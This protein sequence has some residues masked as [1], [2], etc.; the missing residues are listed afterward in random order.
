[1]APPPARCG[2][3]GR[4]AR[5]AARCDEVGWP[6]LQGAAIAVEATSAEG[7]PAAVQAGVDEVRHRSGRAIAWLRAVLVVLALAAA[8]LQGSWVVRAG[9]EGAL[10]LATAITLGAVGVAVAWAGTRLVERAANRALDDCTGRL[11]RAHG[12]ALALARQEVSAQR[13]LVLAAQA[14][15]ETLARLIAHDLK[16]PL[17]AVLQLVSLAESRVATVP[18]LEAAREDLRLA[19]EEAQRLAGMVGDLLLVSRLEHGTLQPRRQAT[20]VAA[21]LSQ[22]GRATALRAAD[23]AVGVTVAADPDLM[24]TL[25]LDLARRLLENLLV[26]ALRLVDRAGRV[27]LAAWQD[28]GDL[29]LAVRSSGSPVP[30]AARPHLFQ[31]HPPGALRQLTGLGLYLGRLVAEAHGGGLALVETPGWPVAFEARLPAPPG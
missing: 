20:P 5:R 15:S 23:R 3:R 9:L 16:N 2:P 21:L 22:V 25:D 29:V 13:E 30:E 10:A 1:M 17:A 27:E 18:G 4:R 14:E 24:G 12:D 28:G 11:V 26:S 31:K 6:R 8:A 7:L 19:E